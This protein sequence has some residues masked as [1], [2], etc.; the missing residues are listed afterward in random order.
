GDAEERRSEKSAEVVVA[1]RQHG[2][3]WKTARKGPSLPQARRTERREERGERESLEGQKPEA[4]AT[5]GARREGYGLERPERTRQRRGRRGGARRRALRH[6]PP[7]GR[8]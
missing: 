7:D 8:G 5:R 6:R 1:R 2:G 3:A 4:R